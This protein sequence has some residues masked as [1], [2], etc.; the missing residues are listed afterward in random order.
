MDYIGMVICGI[1]LS[2]YCHTAML[3]SSN[4]N[5][6]VGLAARHLHFLFFLSGH[7]QL[8]SF[9]SLCIVI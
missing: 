6:F 2:A 4:D 3:W 5:D 1:V 8:A 9:S 7:L